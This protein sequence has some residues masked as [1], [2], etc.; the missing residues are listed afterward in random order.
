VGVEVRCRKR[1]PP[2][3][4]TIL[5]YLE[6]HSD[7]VFTYRDEQLA[8]ETKAKASALGFT[9]WALHRR[10]LI[11]KQDAGGKVYFGS[12]AAIRQL[13]EKLGVTDDDP[14]SRADRNR[15][16]IRERHGHIDV[17]ALLDD[18]REGR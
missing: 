11:G 13:R 15:E 16:R 6:A 12:K 3:Q 9:L 18:V 17:Q 14:F 10:D 8:R 5:D 7:E 2:L 4:R 1:L